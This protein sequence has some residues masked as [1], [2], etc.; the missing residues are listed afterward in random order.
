QRSFLFSNENAHKLY[1][2]LPLCPFCN[3][4]RRPNELPCEKAWVL[5][6][7]GLQAN[8]EGAVVG[9]FWGSGSVHKGS[10]VT[11][12]RFSSFLTSMKSRGSLGRVAIISGTLAFLN[13]FQSDLALAQAPCLVAAGSSN[14]T[15]PS[16]A[17]Q[18]AAALAA[19]AAALAAAQAAALARQA[20]A[21]NNAAQAARQASQVSMAAVQS[22][23][24][25]IRDS[26]QAGRSRP[27]TSGRPIGFAAEPT[28]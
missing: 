16:M 24:Q 2:S 21:F 6:K 18:C 10:W 12:T 22:Q 20:A 28:S 25:S 3:A 1:Y 23:V 14:A 11:D 26:I 15:S 27:V 5:R 7:R 19:Q 13:I 9:R 8:D 17:P 4:V